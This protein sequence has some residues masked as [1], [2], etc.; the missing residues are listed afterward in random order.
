LFVSVTVHENGLPADTVWVAGVFV[1]PRLGQL[2]IVVAVA[3]TLLTPVAA[4]VAVLTMPLSLQLV[5]AV[6]VALMTATSVA[7]LARFFGPQVSVPAVIAHVASLPA[8]S[9]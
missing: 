5:P 2:M 1:I 6:V 7:F 9:V 4:P 8:P 3:C